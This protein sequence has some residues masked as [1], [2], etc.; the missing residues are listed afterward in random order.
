[1]TGPWIS[2]SR[3]CATCLYHQRGRCHRSPPQV[4]VSK[5]GV[6]L[7]VWPETNPDDWCGEH[8]APIKPL[9]QAQAQEEQD[10]TPKRFMHLPDGVIEKETGAGHTVFKVK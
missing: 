10:G 8:E 4:V 3:S 2:L 6:L 5:G 1:M 7:T 9:P